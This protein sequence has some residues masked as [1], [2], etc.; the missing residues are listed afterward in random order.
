VT[1]YNKLVQ[2][3]NRLAGARRKCQEIGVKLLGDIPLHPSICHDADAGKPTV[4]ASPDGTQAQAFNGIVEQI[5]AALEI[6]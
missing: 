4:V 5:T 6:K 2:N 3:A 1:S